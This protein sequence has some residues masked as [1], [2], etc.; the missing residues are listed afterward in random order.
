[1]RVVVVGGGIAGLAAAHRLRE[2]A[3]PGLEIVVV[4]QAGRLGGKLRTGQIEGGPVE[5]GA[6]MFLA[7]EEGADSAVVRL[8]HRVGLGTDLVHPAPLP[9]AI[10]V[11][12]RHHPVPAGTLLG[13]PSDPSTLDDLAHPEAQRDRDGG[14]PL[15]APDEDVAVGALVRR[16]LGDE[17]VDRLVDPMLGGV[18]A[19]RADQLSLAATMPGLHAGAQRH[20]TLVGAVR[21]TLAAA[22]RPPG[23]PVFATIRG[24]LS[25]LIDAVATASAATVRFGAPVRE[26][27][28]TRSGWRVVI[29]STVDSDA[30]EADAVVLALP[31]APAARLLRG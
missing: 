29:G 26:L 23:Q 2:L 14:H 24:G 11:A 21:A 22:P 30:V 31:A 19:G 25:R 9:A 6:E 15:L 28:A 7:R 5:T 3:G 4:E 18:Y 8:A 20:P 17:V 13:V 27:S 16:R 12:G 1:M 10:V